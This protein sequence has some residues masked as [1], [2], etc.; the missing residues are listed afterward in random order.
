MESLCM[1]SFYDALI[2]VIERSDEVLQH[3]FELG[4]QCRAAMVAW[5]QENSA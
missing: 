3:A 1:S 2:A 5:A 4:K